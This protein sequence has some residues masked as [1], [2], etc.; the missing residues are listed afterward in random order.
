M[1][2]KKGFTL[3]E[4]LVVIAIIGLLSSVVLASLS[5]ARK[6][7]QYTAIASSLQEVH[8]AFHLLNLDLGYWPTETNNPTIATLVADSSGLGKYLSQAPEW[9][10][11]GDSWHYDNEGDARPT[12]CSSDSTAG[13]NIS[14]SG[15][16]YEESEALEKIL[17]GGDPSP[18]TSMHCGKIIYNSAGTGQ[19]MFV[20]SPTQ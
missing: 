15:V 12:T 14:V 13:V 9:P 5:S 20:I 3:I 4:L 18:N 10:F 7:A 1:H 6:K 16:E 11:S 19:M 17:D 8:K 2:K